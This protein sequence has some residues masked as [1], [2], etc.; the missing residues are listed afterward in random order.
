MPNSYEIFQDIDPMIV[1]KS[2]SQIVT[3]PI[4]KLGWRPTWRWGIALGLLLAASFAKVGG[5][6]PFLYFRF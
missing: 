4:V 6:S 3:R 2:A 1:P 5:E